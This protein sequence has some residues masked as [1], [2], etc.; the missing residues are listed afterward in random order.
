M[1]YSIISSKKQELMGI[2]I[3]W[4]FLFHSR[5]GQDIFLLKDIV[6]FGSQGVDMFFF[7]SGL[8][9]SYS[10]NR[11]SN[12]KKF[13]LRRFWR[14]APTFFLFLIVVHIIGT[15]LGFPHPKTL[16]QC[17][18]WY[19]TIGWW[20][21]GL[22]S[23][24]YCYFYEWYLPTLILFYVFAP[25]LKKCSIKILLAIMVVSTLLSLV[26]SYSGLLEH[27]YWSYQRIAV[28]VEGFLFYKLIKNHLITKSINYLL[29]TLF[30]GGAFLILSSSIFSDEQRVFTLAIYRFSMLLGMPVFLYI[31]S[32]TLCKTPYL[33]SF[34]RICGTLSLE[35]YLLHIYSR[36][37]SY[38]RG[39]ILENNTLS[40]ILTFFI[41]IIL[42]Y[43]INHFVEIITSR[44][45][46][47]F[48]YKC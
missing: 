36:P 15:W 41:L 29:L 32:S 35:L 14:I 42:A 11:N 22:F 23:N 43:I 8:G 7:L 9:L 16:L 34:L 45:Q 40:I 48:N 39:Y 37:L 28:Y 6:G 13:Y 2:A 26:F 3:L 12:I 27:I 33:Q 30:A 5:F 38:V 20:I 24:P 46:M 44:T 31:L 1:S 18:C 10:L 4:I 47:L 25:V 21:N 17:F 19:S